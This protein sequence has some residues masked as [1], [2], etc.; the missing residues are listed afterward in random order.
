MKEKLIAISGKISEGLVFAGLVVLLAV[1]AVI[2]GLVGGLVSSAGATIRFGKKN[3]KKLIS[4]GLVIVLIAGYILGTGLTLVQPNT[5]KVVWEPVG[6]LNGEMIYTLV[7][8]VNES[9]NPDLVWKWPMYPDFEIKSKDFS[10]KIPL[11]SFELPVLKKEVSLGG[12]QI[13]SP[14]KWLGAQWAQMGRTKEF[15]DLKQ[16]NV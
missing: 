1:L 13:T 3:K 6:Y 15:I 14:V 9:E 10:F 16:L 7:P 11:V 8:H 4:A 2:N 5:V 12:W